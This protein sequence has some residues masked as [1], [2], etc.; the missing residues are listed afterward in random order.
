MAHN[1]P[2]GI[3]DDIT[4]I[5]A[6][7]RAARLIHKTRC[8]DEEIITELPT[9]LDYEIAEGLADAGLLKLDNT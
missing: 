6:T 1:D 9:L 2:M 4:R 7:I 8:K 3:K 5:K